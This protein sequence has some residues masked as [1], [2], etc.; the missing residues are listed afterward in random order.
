MSLKALGMSLPSWQGI[1]MDAVGS[2]FLPLLVTY[3][4]LKFFLN[5][6][7]FIVARDVA[8]DSRAGKANNGQTPP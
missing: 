1:I 7:C 4:S 2:Q 6:Y 8:Q 5:S 3:H